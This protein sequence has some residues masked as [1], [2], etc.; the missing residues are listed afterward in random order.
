MSWKVRRAS[1]K[2]FDAFIVSSITN[3]YLESVGSL[4]I[5]R[6]REREESVLIEVLLS[7]RNLIKRL[8]RHQALNQLDQ[9]SF[10]ASSLR[11][12]KSSKTK[13]VQN[14]I[15]N[16]SAV[17]EADA[18]FLS[19]SLD[20]IVA[21][22]SQLMSKTEETSIRLDIVNFCAAVS[23][24]AENCSDQILNVLERGISDSFYKIVSESFRVL[25]KLVEKGAKP[26]KTINEL[27]LEKLRVSDID[28]EVKD[29]VIGCAGIFC[30]KNELSADQ[31]E[32]A[33]AVLFKHM[34][35]EITRQAA[36]KSL[37]TAMENPASAKFVT[38][39]SAQEVGTLAS[40][41]RKNH[42]LLRVSTL[43]LVSSLIQ[44]GLQKCDEILVELPLLINDQG[45]V[46]TFDR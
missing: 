34:G 38:R 10:V 18:S 27:I 41:L 30:S 4:L 21:P 9:E 35:N 6:T 19:K 17:C 5:Q 8:G 1:A 32:Q 43:N 23:A 20:R 28:Q 37:Q 40:F 31:Q 15:L 39:A 14:T 24:N 25:A 26:T 45:L 33:V 36:V 16:L 3:K 44:N 29:A 7:L 22:I 2:C 13:I 12:L 46:I 42:R 11:L